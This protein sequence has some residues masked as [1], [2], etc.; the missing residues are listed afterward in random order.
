MSFE[1]TTA[2]NNVRGGRLNMSWELVLLAFGGGLFGAAIGAQPAFIFTGFCLIAGAAA[3][4]GGAE[5]DFISNI[6][7][8][9]LF[10]PHVFFAGGVAGAAFAGKKGLITTGKDILTPLAG[11]GIPAPLIVGGVFGIVGQIAHTVIFQNIGSYVDSVALTVVISAIIAR[12][13]FGRTAL[14]GK[15]AGE[16]GFVE[17]FT[18]KEDRVWLSWQQGLWQ[19]STIGIGAG[20]LS[21]GIVMSIITFSPELT[22]VAGVLGFGISAVSLLFLQIGY[23]VPVTHHIT[24]V[25]A[26]ATIMTGSLIAGTVAGVAAA[27]LGELFSRL[28]LINGDTHIDPPACSIAVLTTVLILANNLIG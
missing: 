1:A 27:L 18:P 7:L 25:A 21:A 15:S 24:L 14:F 2:M 13:L 9:P 6:A 4:I 16:V 23:K 28:M 11:L 8:G 3:A 22:T 26:T 12:F 5:F 19:V 10:G 17:R 20:I